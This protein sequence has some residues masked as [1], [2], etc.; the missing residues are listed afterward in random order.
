MIRTRDF[1]I[2][3]H[4]KFLLTRLKYRRKMKGV[5][6]W[7]EAEER[8]L[9][10][11]NL[12]TTNWPPVSRGDEEVVFCIPLIGR[13][14][15]PD[16]NVVCQLLARTLGSL[17]HQSNTKWRAI[18]C[19][20]DEPEAMPPDERITYLPFIAKTGETGKNDSAAKIHQIIEHIKRHGPT[21]GYAFRLDADD[22]PHRDLVDY[23]LRDNNGRGYLLDQG[24]ML[25]SD[26]HHG[27][28]LGHRSL[29]PLRIENNTFFKNCGS[30]LA[31]F[32]DKR[33]TGIG[34]VLADNLLC[35]KHTRLAEV[36]VL[37]AL[38]LAFVPFPAMCYMIR[39]GQNDYPGRRT[40]PVLAPKYWKEIETGFPAIYSQS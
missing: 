8:S 5:L 15:A 25:D 29:F 33:G 30:C 9:K 10:I 40:P 34:M 6:S 22:V 2:L 39:H 14:R 19:S 32:F 23:I 13:E 27:R 17:V 4:R 38:D 36:S 28:A 31:V 1:P 16:W 20:Q 37:A 21:S 26:M 24:Y 3:K 18:V 12:V 35:E 11:R 7:G